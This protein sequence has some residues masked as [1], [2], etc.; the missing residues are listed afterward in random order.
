MGYVRSE[1][2]F[3]SGAGDEYVNLDNHTIYVFVRGDLKEESQLVQAAHAVFKMALVRGVIFHAI[4]DTGEP[5]I[6]FLDGG[7]SAK[8]FGRTLRKL[9]EKKVGI[10]TYVDPDSLDNGITAMATGP[11]TKEESFPLANYRLRHYSPA[12]KASDDAPL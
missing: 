3:D 8:A 2:C 4:P 12:V 10:V 7:S 6:V 9:T 5:S 11:L 1:E